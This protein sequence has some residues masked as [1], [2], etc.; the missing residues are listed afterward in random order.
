MH[1]ADGPLQFHGRCQRAITAKRANIVDHGCAGADGATHHGRLAGIDR[2]RYVDRRDNRLDDRNDTVEFFLL[3]DIGRTRARGLAADVNDRSTVPRHSLGLPQRGVTARKPAAIRERIGG[4]V[5][6][7]H[8][9]GEV[10]C[11]R[12]D[13]QHGFIARRRGP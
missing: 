1:Q 6:D 13:G 12:A 5:E 9:R 3:G 7:P 10:E 11:K 4:D 8:Y 2:N